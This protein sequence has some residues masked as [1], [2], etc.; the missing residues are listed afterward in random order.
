MSLTIGPRVTSS[1]SSSS[2][3][4]TKTANYTILST[5]S[6]IFVDTSGGAFTLT[7]PAP[8][9][10]STS[11]TTKEFTIID[12]KG[13]LNTNNITLAPSSS[14]KISGLAASK[15][16]ETDWGYYKVTTNNTDWFLG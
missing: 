1:G 3:F 12:T 8:S 15:L 6:V 9:S 2:N 13:T 14:E 16:L 11:T 4:V 5:D 7:L 10:V